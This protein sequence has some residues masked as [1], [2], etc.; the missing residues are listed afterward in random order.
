M[1]HIFQSFPIVLVVD[2]NPKKTRLQF[3]RR[4]YAN[5]KVQIADINISFFYLAKDNYFT[6][7]ILT[8]LETI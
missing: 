1:N 4:T 8:F 3:I 2:S 7:N 6:R 5:F